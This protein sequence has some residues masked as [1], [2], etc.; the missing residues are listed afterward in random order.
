MLPLDMGKSDYFV[1]IILT[2]KV[3]KDLNK[4]NIQILKFPHIEINIG[5]IIKVLENIYLKNRILFPTTTL[6]DKINKII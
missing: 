3:V 5:I 6:I 1:R 2:I 4:M